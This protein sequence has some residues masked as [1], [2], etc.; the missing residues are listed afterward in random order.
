VHGVGRHGDD[1]TS[2][3]VGAVLCLLVEAAAVITEHVVVGAIAAAGAGAC[4]SVAYLD[5]RRRR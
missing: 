4:L 5:E 1:V 2:L 3:Y